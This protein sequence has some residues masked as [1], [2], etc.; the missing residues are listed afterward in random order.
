MKEWHEGR[1]PNVEVLRGNP[2]SWT[3]EHWAQVLGSCASEDGDYIYDSNNVKVIHTKEKI[4]AKLFKST[5]SQQERMA[6]D[7]VPRSDET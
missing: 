4:F 6:D 7:V 5:S 1:A 3:I 2:K